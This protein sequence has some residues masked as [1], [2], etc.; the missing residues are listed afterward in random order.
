MEG[1][2]AGETVVEGPLVER[3]TDERTV[4]EGTANKKLE[5]DDQELRTCSKVPIQM[6]RCFSISIV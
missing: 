4:V 2:L 3:P 6:F 1:T 5:V